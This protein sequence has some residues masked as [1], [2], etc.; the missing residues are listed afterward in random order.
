MVALAL[1]LALAGFFRLANLAGVRRV[2][3]F[4]FW[5]GRFFADA[6]FSATFRARAATVPGLAR[7]S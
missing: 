6:S 4:L 5:L 2:A 7:G 3:A 1:L